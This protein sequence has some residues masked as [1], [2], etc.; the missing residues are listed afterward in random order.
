MMFPN[1][2]L[3]YSFYKLY[4]NSNPQTENDHG[5]NGEIK[6]KV[7]SFDPDITGQSADPV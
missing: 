3:E 5:S 6:S 2:C 1:S 7:L 4:D